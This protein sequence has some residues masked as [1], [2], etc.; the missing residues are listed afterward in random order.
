MPTYLCPLRRV[1][2]FLKRDSSTVD[3]DPSCFPRS[4][5][6][7]V[8]MQACRRLSTCLHDWTSPVQLL[9]CEQKTIMYSCPIAVTCA[10]FYHYAQHTRVSV[11]GST[12]TISSPYHGC[13]S[14]A[15]NAGRIPSKQVKEGRRHRQRTR[16]PHSEASSPRPGLARSACDQRGP[17]DAGA[18][19]RRHGHGPR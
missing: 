8:P 3:D 19:P 16:D 10:K 18:R 4:G 9:P 14:Q 12:H 1:G 6:S 11:Q 17:H 13:C 15:E 7:Q 5:T 2:D